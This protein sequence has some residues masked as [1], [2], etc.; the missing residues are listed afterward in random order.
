MQNRQPCWQS[1]RCCAR[2]NP[3]ASS[4]KNT[5]SVWVCAQTTQFFSTDGAVFLYITNDGNLVLYN[6]ANYNKYGPS[7]AGSLIWQ[8]KT[9][10]QSASQPFQLTMQ[11][12]RACLLI[13]PLAWSGSLHPPWQGPMPCHRRI[14]GRAA[15]VSESPARCLFYAHHV[16]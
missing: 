9:G 2:F 16:H 14:W 10:G 15:S 3:G 6:T 12:V 7:S 13:A 8:S 11:N 1:G 5:G 4:Q